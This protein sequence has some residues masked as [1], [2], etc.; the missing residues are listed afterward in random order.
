MQVELRKAE[1]QDLPFILPLYAQ[2][3]LDNGQILPL[4]PARIIFASMRDYPDYQLYVAMVQGEIVGVFAL[5]I[6]DNLGHL[7][8]PSGVVEG[9]VVREDWRR[10]GIGQKMM[11]FAM[12]YCK[13]RGCYKL[14]LSSNLQREEAHRFYERLGFRKHGYSFVVELSPYARSLAKTRTGTM[15]LR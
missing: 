6:M 10:Q 15:V 11:G 7:G 14:A 8:A 12:E 13:S 4:E 5:L 9:V 1:E 2:L 3:G